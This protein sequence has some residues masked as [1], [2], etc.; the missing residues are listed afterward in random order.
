MVVNYY[1]K[2]VESVNWKPVSIVWLFIFDSLNMSKTVSSVKSLKF[3]YSFCT[4]L[5]T[6]ELWNKKLR[7]K[8][9]PLLWRWSLSKPF[10]KMKN[11]VAERT[12][13]CVTFNSALWLS[14]TFTCCITSHKNKLSYSCLS[15]TWNHI[16]E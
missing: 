10:K 11:N 8:P 2:N 3:L 4:A 6:M 1:D 12:E 14:P 15:D 7:H 16:C 13:P 9:L 5:I